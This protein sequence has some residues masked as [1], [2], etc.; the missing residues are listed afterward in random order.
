VGGLACAL[1]VGLGEA[2]I[3]QSPIWRALAV[4]AGLSI[5]AQ[6][7]D[8]LESGVK[9]HFGVKDSSRLIPGHG[10]LLDRLDGL[11]AAA[12]LA[13]LLAAALGRGVEL[14]R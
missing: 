10:G 6:A 2:L 12:P 4:V 1:A 3:S 9:R 14:W 11:L 13:A 7:G 5:A 8:L